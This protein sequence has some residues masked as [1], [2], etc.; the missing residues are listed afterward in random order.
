M[1]LIVPTP[2]PAAV[3]AVR[4]ALEPAGAPL[5]E[6]VASVRTSGVDEPSRLTLPV[7]GLG[8][9]AAGIADTVP[10]LS[11]QHIVTDAQSGRRATAETMQSASTNT[12]VVSRVTDDPPFLQATFAATGDAPNISEDGDYE[13]RVMAV[14]AVY[15]LAIWLMNT[16]DRTQDKFIVIDAGELFAPGTRLDAATWYEALLIE[17]R[18]IQP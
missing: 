5:T 12:Y 18:R 15:A 7:Y 2:P 9:T 4:A 14:P 11:W 1:A 10:L 17:A 3:E 6:G 8:V 13:L 16:A